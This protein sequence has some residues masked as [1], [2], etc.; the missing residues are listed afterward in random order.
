LLAAYLEELGRAGGQVPAFEDAW[1][2]Y[3]QQSMF[4]YAAWAF[5]IG[6]AVY[7]PEMQ[8]NETC[9]TLMKRITTA[10]DDHDSLGALGV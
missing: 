3:R 6:R 9:S 7:Q 2:R 5:T 1:L 4:A 8:S 10:I